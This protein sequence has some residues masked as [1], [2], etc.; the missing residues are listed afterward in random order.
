MVRFMIRT[1]LLNC[2][3]I[4]EFDFDFFVSYYN[5]QNGKTVNIEKRYLE[6]KNV[7]LENNKFFELTNY[8]NSF[9]KVVIGINISSNCNL[10]CKYCFS[11]EKALAKLDIYKA[12]EFIEFI[13]TNKNNAEIFFVDMAGSGEPLLYLNDVLEIADFCRNISNQIGKEVTPMLST[14]GL[15]LNPVVVKALQNHNILFGVSLDGYK[16]LHDANR[17]DHMGNPTFDKIVSNVREIEFNESVG[18][19]MTIS[20]QNTDIYKSYIEMMDLFKTVAIRPSRM[21]YENFSFDLIKTGYTKF[22]DYLVKE[23][24]NGN[25]T[26]L[27]Q[28][29]NGDDFFGKFIL[30]IISNAKLNRRCE[31]GCARFAMSFD[32]KIYPCSPAIYHNELEITKDQI[33]NNENNPYFT[34]IPIKCEQCILKNVCGSDCYVLLYEKVSETELCEFKKFLFILSMKFCGTIEIMSFDIYTDI[35]KIS[36]NILLRSYKNKELDFVYNKYKNKYK[37]TE[38]KQIMDNDYEYF[39]SLKNN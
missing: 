29:I 10:R 20:L 3:N 18:G 9:P 11:K 33:K 2:E 14:N 13:V 23:T 1:S 34:S 4:L 27:T 22:Y 39:C 30:K 5:I 7:I 12:K 35:V 6:Y 15:F 8:S 28:I 26:P 17:L 25:L 37:F 32:G 16:E 31:A 21:S 24:L 36:N 19:S 38:L